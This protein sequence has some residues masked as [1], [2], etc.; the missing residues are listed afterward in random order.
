MGEAGVL[1]RSPPTP[2]AEAAERGGG[3]DVTDRFS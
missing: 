1:G 2:R 3:R